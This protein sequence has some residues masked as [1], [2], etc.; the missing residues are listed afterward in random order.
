MVQRRF[1]VTQ[2]FLGRFVPEVRLVSEVTVN[3]L[4]LF[5]LF[6]ESLPS[7]QEV[8]VLL[9]YTMSWKVLLYQIIICYSTI[10]KID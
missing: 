5:M 7:V 4:G 10:Y 6:Q 8:K 9:W 2:T 1:K 3:C